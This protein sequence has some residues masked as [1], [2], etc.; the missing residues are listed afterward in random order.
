M[1]SLRVV[2]VNALDL[3]GKNEHTVDSVGLREAGRRIG[4]GRLKSRRGGL[5]RKRSERP[6]GQPGQKE[7]NAG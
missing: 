1:L 7:K 4:S 3:V 5:Q 6:D 2:G